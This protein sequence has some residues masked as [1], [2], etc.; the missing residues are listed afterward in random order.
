V[1]TFTQAKNSK[2]VNAA[3]FRMD[4][5]P[6]GTI[7]R[8]PAEELPTVE[9]VFKELY[10]HQLDAAEVP[11]RFVEVNFPPRD[12]KTLC[13]AVRGIKEGLETGWKQ[14]QLA[15]VPQNLI[16]NGFSQ[17]RF[18]M[19]GQKW[20]WKAQMADDLCNGGDATHK[21]SRLAAFLNNSG[22]FFPIEGAG[23][24]TVTGLNAVTSILA[25]ARFWKKDADGNERT[26]QEKQQ[27]IESPAFQNI[28]IWLDEAH[29]V[30]GASD[31]SERELGNVN[32]IIGDFVSYA[33]HYGHESLRVTLAT[34]TPYN[35]SEML[36]DETKKAFVSI[37]RSFSDYLE[38]PRMEIRQ[39]VVKPVE[40]SGS[41][42][43][44]C[45][46]NEIKKAGPGRFHLAFIPM[47]GQS[48]RKQK[49]NTPA[50]VAMIKERLEACVPWAK[51]LDATTHEGGQKLTAM[52]GGA[53]SQQD[54]N[55]VLTCRRGREGLD[56]LPADFLHVL[57]LPSQLWESNQVF[58]RPFSAF[59]GKQRVD[60]RY[61]TEAKEDTLEKF[62][63]LVLTMRMALE[64]MDF[65][66]P[67]RVVGR[68][69][70]GRRMR[71]GNAL[72]RN[73]GRGVSDPVGRVLANYGSDPDTVA[74]VQRL[75][76]RLVTKNFN[77]EEA[78][79]SNAFTEATKQYRAAGRDLFRLGKQEL[80]LLQGTDLE[81]DPRLAAWKTAVEKGVLHV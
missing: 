45:F 59:P 49:I 81:F 48:W 54:Y 33:V 58:T 42:P 44:T 32:N 41:S 34:A 27:L 70:E 51:F 73:M 63:T 46:I 5:I 69:K 53:A 77:Y 57:F 15:A 76:A 56:W 36:D 68:I 40:C 67:Q 71:L 23:F 64:Q 52:Q 6:R 30:R 65:I 22:P 13:Q 11:G 61:Y 18:C 50:L 21:R 3:A 38:N 10:Q 62:D 14:R 16:G 9:V 17:S 74:H 78:H 39:A 66:A 37:K 26:E 72:L 60:V 31:P 4:I 75:F 8:R 20:E 47:N 43:V 25:L 28:T 2:G 1:I 80:A 79:S 19:A 29:H 55:I 12:G 35:S 7:V 24:K